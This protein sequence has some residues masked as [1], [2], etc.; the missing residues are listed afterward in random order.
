MRFDLKPERRMTE[1]QFV[2]RSHHQPICA[3]LGI[4]ARRQALPL[5]TVDPEQY[6]HYSQLF[7]FVI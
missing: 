6:Y 5:K 7:E 1:V 4:G 3:V 2:V